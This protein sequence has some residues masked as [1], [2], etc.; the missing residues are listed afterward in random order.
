MEDKFHTNLMHI[1]LDML[2]RRLKEYQPEQNQG[3]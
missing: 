3:F 2:P 1:G